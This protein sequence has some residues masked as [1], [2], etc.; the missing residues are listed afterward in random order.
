MTTRKRGRPFLISCPSMVT[1]DQ[2]IG[3]TIH[4]LVMWG[5]P[6]R[7]VCQDIRELRVTSLLNQS[8]IR[9]RL[10]LTAGRLEQIY[11]GWK[12]AQTGRVNRQFS[13]VLRYWDLH[14]QA[15][16]DGDTERMEHLASTWPVFEPPRERRGVVTAFLESRRP[17]G[18]AFSQLAAVLLDNGGVW[19]DDIRIGAAKRK[20]MRESSHW[21]FHQEDWP[22][23]PGHQQTITLKKTG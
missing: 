1:A 19:P 4:M 22:M 3:Q 21:V 11:E 12:D 16:V 15:F 20:A 18:I 7:K 14:Y 2:V 8:P 17:K 23:T 5:F 9:D 6:Y 13:E 10:S